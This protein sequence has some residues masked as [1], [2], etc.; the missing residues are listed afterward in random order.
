MAGHSYGAHTAFA[1]AGGEPA[2]TRIAAVAGLEPFTRTLPPSVFARVDVPSLLVAGAHDT[3]TPPETDADPAFAAL[4]AEDARLVRIEHAGHQA[5]SDVGL[6]LELAPQVG[7]LPELASDYLHSLADQVTGRAGDPWRPTVGL[8]LRIL[9]AWLDA[10]FDRH[11]DVARHNLTAVGG[12]P[13]VA[14]RLSDTA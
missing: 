7:G 1:L 10:I 8:H 4:G 11:A 6:Y 5:C 2:E 3:A 13:G 9:V 14:M 12:L